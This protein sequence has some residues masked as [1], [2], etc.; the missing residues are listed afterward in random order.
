MHLILHGIL[1]LSLAHSLV[2]GVRADDRAEAI[3]VHLASPWLSSPVRRESLVSLPQHQRRLIVS[4]A[5]QMER[6][7]ARPLFHIVGFHEMSGGAGA[8]IVHG[9]RVTD[10]S[11]DL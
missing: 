3:P 2:V 1:T 7:P 8:Q 9:L 5:G 11:R 4:A 10:V 6:C